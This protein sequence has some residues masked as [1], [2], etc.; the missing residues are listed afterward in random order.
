M[1]FQKDHM[2]DEAH[3]YYIIDNEHIIIGYLLSIV[4]KTLSEMTDSSSVLLIGT[5]ISDMKIRQC[6][7]V[8]R[9]LK[10]TG[11]THVGGVLKDLSQMNVFMNDRRIPVFAVH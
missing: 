5:N 7:T 9:R 3:A 8:S 11:I 1:I 2:L 4:S 10:D 6:A